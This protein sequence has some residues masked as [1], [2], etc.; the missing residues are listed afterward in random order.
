MITVIDWFKEYN[1]INLYLVLNV[2]SKS[3]VLELTVN[4]QNFHIE[5]ILCC[6]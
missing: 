2:Y 4:L 1:K 6:I 5:Y 3:I